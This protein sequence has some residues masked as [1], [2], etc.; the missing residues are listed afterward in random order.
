MGGRK[1][2]YF[3][4]NIIYYWWLALQLNSLS[5]VWNKLNSIRYNQLHFNIVSILFEVGTCYYF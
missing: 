2:L 3:V 5:F 4:F 1:I